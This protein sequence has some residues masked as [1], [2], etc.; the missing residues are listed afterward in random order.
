VVTCNLGTIKAGKKASVMIVV[1][2]TQPGTITDKGLVS[3]AVSDP[4]QSNNSRSAT[5]TVT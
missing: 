4:V 1:T 3:S 5:T 2:P